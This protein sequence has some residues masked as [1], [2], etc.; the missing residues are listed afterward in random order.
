MTLSAGA[1]AW[2]T[3]PANWSGPFGIPTLA[4][5]HLGYTLAALLLAGL[6]AVPAGWAIGHTGRG[7]SIAV[8]LAGAARALP[9]LGLLAFLV[10]I[11]GVGL[12]EAAA[13]V[14]LVVLAIPPIL[15]GS[16]AGIDAIPGG[17]LDSARGIGMTGWQR[18]LR[19]EAPLGLPLL[20]GGV[21]A[22]SLQVVS[23]VMIAA[24][25][26][27]PNL[28]TYLIA[29]QRLGD[30]PRMLAGAILVVLLALAL[31]GALALIQRLT[32]PRGVRMAAA[33]AVPA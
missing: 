18:L 12:K 16:Y 6:F 22:A 2:L 21:R 1:F 33:M 10:L 7:R 13:V 9:S 23:T 3:D 27:L 8:A 5:N 14:V 11:F 29:G 32:V 20:M 15:A 24:F 30:Y 26:G 17:T 4:L 31:D 28:G 25:I 19:V